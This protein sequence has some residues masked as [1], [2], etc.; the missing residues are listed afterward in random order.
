MGLFA[1]CSKGG[2]ETNLLKTFLSGNVES[3]QDIIKISNQSASK[4]KVVFEAGSKKNLEQLE[5]NFIENIDKNYF[6]ITDLEIS[7]I[8][9]KSLSSPSNFLSS[10]TK[11]LLKAEKY[12]EIYQKSLEKLYNPAGISLTD[13]E[14]DPFMLFDDYILSM[15]TKSVKTDFDNGKFYD[16]VELKMKTKENLSPES[17]N[18]IIKKLVKLQQKLSDK[19]SRIYLAGNLIHSYYTSKNSV[20]CINIICILSLFLIG[21][22]TYFYFRNFKILVPIFCTIA[23]GMYTGYC[24]T[25]IWFENFQVV[26]MVFST[27]LIGIGI[28]Y[29]YHYFFSK[30]HDKT[31]IKKLTFSL[32]TTI[33]PFLFLYLT[34]IELLKQIAV[35][36]VFGLISI[37]FVV[38]FIYPSFEFNPPQKNIKL[39][40]KIFKSVA[41]ILFIIAL[42]GFIKLYFNDTL[43]AFYTPSKELIKAEKLYSKISGQN[44]LQTQFITVYGKDLTQILSKEEKIT[45]KLEDG[46]IDYIS[47][48]K[49]FPSHKKQKENFGLVKKLYDKKLNNYSEILTS[50]QISKLKNQTFVPVVFDMKNSKVLP[51]FLTDKNTSLI[52][53][54][55]DKDLNIGTKLI[56][57]QKSISQ[58]LKNYRQILIKIFPVVLLLMFAFLSVI[59]GIKQGTKLTLPSLFGVICAFG[60]SLVVF[61]ELNL[62]SIIALFLVLGFTIDYSI[63]RANP[64]T[65][66]EDAIF[67][68]C[69]TTA[70]SFLMLSLTGFKLV[71][72][73][74]FVLFSGIIS[75]YIFGYLIF[76]NERY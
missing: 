10:K 55:S 60:T 72:S 16:S 24:I 47:I 42:S 14:K 18:K 59:Y 61:G 29:S 2:V 37:Y 62:F 7:K 26:T 33:I 39:N 46:N 25:R 48:S 38:L 73:I 36:S 3:S 67:V 74:T 17:A 15:Q 51:E 40:I 12:D 35:F 34:G 45:E 32:L 65:Q 30:N 50:A 19:N 28:D 41:V 20:L 1:F 53:I 5:Q 76:N 75:S 6:Q 66:T 68:S 43:S 13:F 8:F 58:Y 70:F 64:A 57:I 56:N 54:F 23:F 21:V 9:K 11:N 27:M 69:L 52:I 71:S 49:I 4:I 22:L 63:F 44:S 31:F